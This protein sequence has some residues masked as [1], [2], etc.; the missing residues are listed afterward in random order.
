MLFLIIIV[1]IFTSVLKTDS[2][3]AKTAATTIIGA[4]VTLIGTVSA[5]Y[6]GASS[7]KAATQ[8]LA[9]ITG[10]SPPPPEAITKGSEPDRTDP[11]MTDLVGNVNPRGQEVRSFFE[12]S[13]K[14]Y[15]AEPST[16][17]GGVSEVRTISPGNT[18]V[19]VRIPVAAKAR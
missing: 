16:Y 18:A 12:Y 1:Y 15:D 11:N 5:F 14:E 3:E 6:F 19:E 13:D 8:A 7:V 17:S 9:T 2:A 4:L 10:Q